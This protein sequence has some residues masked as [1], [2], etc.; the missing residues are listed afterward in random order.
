MDRFLGRGGFGRVSESGEMD[1]E[2]IKL[3]NFFFNFLFLVWSELRVHA[4]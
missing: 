1:S 2:K 3:V 4:E